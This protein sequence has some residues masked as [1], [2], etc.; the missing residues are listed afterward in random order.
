MHWRKRGTSTLIPLLLL[1]LLRDC[2][3]ASEHRSENPDGITDSGTHVGLVVHNASIKRNL[4]CLLAYQL[5]LLQ[6]PR[7]RCC[8]LAL[9]D[10]TLTGV[11][12]PHARARAHS[13]CSTTRCDKIEQLRWRDGVVLEE[14][15]REK[16]SASEQEYFKSYSSLLTRYM[17]ALNLDLTA[18]RA[19]AAALSA[20]C[21]RA[22]NS[23]HRVLALTT[24]PYVLCAG[25]KAT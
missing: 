17:S 1:L 13:H 20:H 15:T 23:R 9:C 18:V 12:L 7:R 25:S 14:G 21:C 11:A 24:T 4:R 16:L 2:T 6:L 8:C 5:V 19:P 22:R 3:R 10:I